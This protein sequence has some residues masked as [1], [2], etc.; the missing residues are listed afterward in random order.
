MTEVFEF[1]EPKRENLI[2][3]FAAMDEAQGS[4]HKENRAKYEAE[5]NIQRAK[6][7]TDRAAKQ[8]G[9]KGSSEGNSE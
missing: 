3:H 5:A 7:A 6:Q 4:I 8:A 9:A 2:Y 1:S